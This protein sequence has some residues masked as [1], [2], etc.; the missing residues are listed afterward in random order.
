MVRLTAVRL[1][2]EYEAQDLIPLFLRSLQTDAD[3]G[4]RAAAATALGKFVYFGEVDKLTTRTR[5]H[6]EENLLRVAQGEDDPL[7]RRRALE[8]LGYS[9]REEV[10]PLIEQAYRSGSRD[11]LISSLIAMGRSANNRWEA[12][13]LPMLENPAIAVRT[14]AVRAAGELELSAARQP[15]LEL[16]QDEDDDVR[17]AAIWSLS[18]IGGRGVR[19]AL[20]EMHAETEDDDE[21]EY[22]ENALDNLAFTEDM[23]MFS[24]FDLEDDDQEEEALERLEDDEDA[25]G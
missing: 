24:I 14:E 9:G 22:L 11:W 12:R 19:E 25:E 2:W 8:S 6:L 10:P 23:G 21:A 3:A 15:L 13:V 5:S 1:L 7:V 17:V 18:Q 4:V 20:E 16:L